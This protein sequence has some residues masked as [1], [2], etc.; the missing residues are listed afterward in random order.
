MARSIERDPSL[1]PTGPMSA[2]QLPT[3]PGKFAG[4]FRA[5]L[6]EGADIS[7]SLELYDPGRN[8]PDFQFLVFY[9]DGTALRGLPDM[10]LDNYIG[11]VRLDISGGGKTCAKWGVYRMAGNRGQVVFASPS[12]GGRQLVSH[13]LVGD[14][15][16][17]QEFP[18]KLQINGND[19][20][21]L[22]GGT[23]GMK[24]EGT[25]KPF[26]DKKSP[27]ITFRRNG[28]FVD[29]GILKTGGATALGIAGGGVAIGYGFSSPGPG[30]GTYRIS[31]Y[32]LHL[33]YANGQRPG[34][35]FWL[36]PGTSRSDVRTIY[37]GN[38]KLVRVQ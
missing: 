29:E 24:I 34:V 38:V 21:M 8:T 26:G 28:E 22:D 4:I 2:N 32:T 3:V 1:P 35:L 17:I 20:V 36:E 12:A 19:Y 13:R 18:D 25:F 14:A 15:W 33:N 5:R 23:A 16:E 27:G 37:L 10:G 30:P 6:R 7:A 9:P 11:S 31:N